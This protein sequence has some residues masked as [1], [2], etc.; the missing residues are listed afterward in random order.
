MKNVEQR[1]DDPEGGLLTLR[2]TQDGRATYR[3]WCRMHV[4]FLSLCISEKTAG[5]N[6][7]G[8]TEIVRRRLKS[9]R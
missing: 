3:L 4:A 8:L 1:R 2:K 7:G 9:A 5:G 6:A